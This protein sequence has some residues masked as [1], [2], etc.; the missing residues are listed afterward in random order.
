MKPEPGTL[1]RWPLVIYLLACTLL[2][3][4]SPARRGLVNLTQPD[5]STVQ[6]Y[7]SGDEHGHLTTTADGCVLTQDAE[8]WWCYAR[9]D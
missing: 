8:G 5:G 7:L 4:A 2:V 1:R 9:F 6:A 3:Q